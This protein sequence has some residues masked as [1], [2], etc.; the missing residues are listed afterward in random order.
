MLRDESDIRPDPDI[1]GA[2]STAVCLNEDG[3][4][5]RRSYCSAVDSQL[6][7]YLTNVSVHGN[8]TGSTQ[9]NQEIW[10]YRLS[11]RV[12]VQLVRDSQTKKKVQLAVE[13]VLHA[14]LP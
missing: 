5:C 11:W 1:F 3:P 13:E 14:H 6:D 8:E 10:R 9:R 7:S 2:L 12:L 4:E